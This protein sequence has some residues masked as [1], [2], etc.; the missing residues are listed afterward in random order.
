MLSTD[1][2]S[3]TIKIRFDISVDRRILKLAFR[4]CQIP[5]AMARNGATFWSG[6]KLQIRRRAPLQAAL[7]RADHL[8]AID[9]AREQVGDRPVVRR[10][11]PQVERQR[12]GQRIDLVEE[13]L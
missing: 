5:C 13:K 8:R 9:E 7:H 1:T 4:G 2:S 11:G 10:G 6:E 12:A 3:S